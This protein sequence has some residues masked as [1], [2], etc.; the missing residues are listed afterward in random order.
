MSEWAGTI[1]EEIAQGRELKVRPNNHKDIP[2]RTIVE[3]A[4]ADA[5]AKLWQELWE[6]AHAPCKFCG[7]KK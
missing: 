3:R 4:L 2:E 6:K 5:K 1:W 7:K